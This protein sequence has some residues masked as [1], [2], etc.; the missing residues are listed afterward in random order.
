MR[1]NKIVF[2]EAPFDAAIILQKQFQFQQNQKK[3]YFTN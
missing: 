3:D 1:F 2:D